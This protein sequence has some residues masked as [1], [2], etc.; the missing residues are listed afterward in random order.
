MRESVQGQDRTGQDKRM[1]CTYTLFHV[2]ERAQCTVLYMYVYS[3]I[4][5]VPA[6]DVVPADGVS[7]VETVALVVEDILTVT[8]IVIVIVIVEGGRELREL[9]CTVL[10]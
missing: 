8:V 2:R 1:H 3:M 10:Y 6:V 5:Y 4:R 7:A 9:Y